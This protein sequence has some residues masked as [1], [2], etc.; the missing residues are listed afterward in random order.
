MPISPL[1]VKR[2]HS[3]RSRYSLDIALA[4]QRVNT[5]VAV[6]CGAMIVAL[7]PGEEDRRS[8]ESGG[9]E[10]EFISVIDCSGSMRDGNKIGQTRRAMLL[11]LKRLPLNC[12]FDVIRLGSNHQSLFSKV[13][14]LYTE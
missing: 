8:G 10:N 3:S 1:L 14:S 2:M 13:T 9:G 11:F 5:I 4:S 7:L 12:H 6:E